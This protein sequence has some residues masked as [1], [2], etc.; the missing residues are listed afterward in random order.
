M[1]KKITFE[2]DLTKTTRNDDGTITVGFG[3]DNNGTVVSLFTPTITFTDTLSSYTNSHGETRYFDVNEDGTPY[4]YYGTYNGSNKS[5]SETSPQLNYNFT[6]KWG[7]GTTDSI[8]TNENISNLELISHNYTTPYKNVEVVIEGDCDGWNMPSTTDKELKTLSNVVTSVIIDDDSDAPFKYVC[9]TFR[10]FSNLLHVSKRV[11]ENCNKQKSFSF[12]FQGC[13]KLRIIDKD[14]F[15]NCVEAVVFKGAFS[16][17]QNLISIPG[18]IFKNCANAA[19][20]YNTFSYCYSLQ[21]MPYNLFE[22]TSARDLSYTFYHNQNILESDSISGNVK[23][24]YKASKNAGYLKISPKLLEPIKNTLKLLYSTFSFN[25]QFSFIDL[26]EV[27]SET[28]KLN[29]YTYLLHRTQCNAVKLTKFNS[30]TEDELESLYGETSVS[31]IAYDPFGHLMTETLSINSSYPET[32]GI[33]FSRNQMLRK[34]Y[35]AADDS[36]MLV[37][38]IDLSKDL[39]VNNNYNGSSIDYRGMFNHTKNDYS[40]NKRLE[41][42]QGDLRY[43]RYAKDAFKTCALKLKSLK[44]IAENIKNVTGLTKD[45]SNGDVKEGH[46]DKTICIGI[47][48]DC[49]TSETEQT[50]NNEANAAINTIKSKG[51]T[52]TLEYNKQINIVQDDYSISMLSNEEYPTNPIEQE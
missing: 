34:D 8:V 32:H 1:A 21:S 38:F 48:P 25:Q 15:K 27:C 22:G 7:D 30:L 20:F 52:V 31:S 36:N 45:S 11:F 41:H 26:G 16:N 10:N 2:L 3:Y 39:P 46:S 17:C 35:I 49:W 51:W 40:F 42:F 5:Y 18:T 4:V 44:Y 28:N 13:K 6:I 12:T 43:C 37:T 47:G 29:V 19:N 14:I 9:R 24:L 50:M 23:E 33:T